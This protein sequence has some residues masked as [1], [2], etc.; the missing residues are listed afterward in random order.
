M[1]GQQLALQRVTLLSRHRADVERIVGL[2]LVDGLLQLA[3][4]DELNVGNGDG[5]S[6]RAPHITAHDLGVAREPRGVRSPRS[7]PRSGGCQPMTYSS[8]SRSNA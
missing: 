2:N 4:I 7:S 3:A 8:T 6:L 5:R 1:L